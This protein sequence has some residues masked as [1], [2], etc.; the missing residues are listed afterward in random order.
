MLICRFRI[1]PPKTVAALLVRR[2][3]A[4]GIA[5]SC[6]TI[7]SLVTSSSTQLILRAP[8]PVVVAAH[9]TPFNTPQ[10]SEE[11][12]ALRR[13]KLT[14]ST[15][16]TA[17][18]FWKGNRRSELWHEKVYTVDTRSIS[19]ASKAAME[20]GVLNESAAIERYKSI[21][22][23]DVG[24]LGFAV[25]AEEQSKWLGASPDGLIGCCPGGGILE[26]KCP[27][28]K[29]KPEH[30]L[31]WSTVPFY[32][33]P[34]VQGQME[35]MDREWVDVY[36]WTLNGSTIFR[37]CRDHEY[38]ELIH[39][40]LWEFWWENIVPAREAFLLGKEEDVKAYKPAPTHNQTGLAISKSLK[41]AAESKL[42]CRD[43][44][45]HTEFYR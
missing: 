25:H 12:F 31:P 15:F 21:T 42:I 23:H 43:I 44:A 8:A 32:C 6:S 36:C 11:W 2:E 38:W 24:F 16:C 3:C 29:G 22:G 9:L 14:T 19:A 13:D 34:Q 7:S 40:I 39:G 37:V 28:N 1:L 20:W 30:A 41:L 10:R 5:R 35:I 17:L 4:S 45:G 26:V 33:M 18:G 27:H